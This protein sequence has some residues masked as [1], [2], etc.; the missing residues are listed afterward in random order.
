MKKYKSRFNYIYKGENNNWVFYNT[1]TNA[2]ILLD[3]KYKCKYDNIE[4]TNDEVFIKQM[5]D[6]GFF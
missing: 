5:N 1:F 4:N 3:D 6:L 2:L